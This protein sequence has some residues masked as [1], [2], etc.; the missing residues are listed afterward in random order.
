M[1]GMCK[2]NY[3]N[4][5]NV[6]DLNS[7]NEIVATEMYNKSRRKQPL[8]INDENLWDIL[9]DWHINT[10]IIKSQFHSCSLLSKVFLKIVEWFLQD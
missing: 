4:Y 9:A 1:I 8:L 2:C 3:P 10:I 7:S 5:I 6:S